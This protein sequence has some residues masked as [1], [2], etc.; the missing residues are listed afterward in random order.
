MLNLLLK[1]FRLMFK[2]NRS[3]V[4]TILSVLF[5][6]VFLGL[7]V[8]LEIYLF[9]TILDK[10]NN[11]PRAPTAFLTLFLFVTTLL[12]I[13]ADLFQAK[14]LFFDAK[15]IEQLST[16]PVTNGQI[17]LSKMVFL[18]ISHSIT[19]LIFQ[20]PLLVAYGIDIGKTALFFFGAFF[21]PIVSFFFV[22]GI[23]LI[24]VY[25]LWLFTSFLKRHFILQFSVSI[26]IIVGLS[27]LYSYALDIF[28]NLVAQN[29]MI[30]LFSDQSIAKFLTF[31]RY[32]V[33]VNFLVD[34]FVYKSMSAI[35]PFSLLSLGLFIIGL[36]ITIYS[37]HMV[38]NISTSDTRIT[39]SHKTRLVGVVPALIKK[40]F[41]LI[42]K[43]SDYIYSFTGLLLVQPLLLQLVVKSINAVLSA[44][45]IMYYTALV[46]G[47][48]TFVDVLVIMFFSVVI[49]Q[50]ANGYITM[51]SNTIKIIKTIP[52]PY[53]IQLAIKVA[54]PYSFSMVS[55]FV[56]LLVLMSTKTMSWGYGF[57]T[58]LLTAIFL[59]VFSLISLNEELH[60]RHNKKKTSFVSSLF[61]YLFPLVFALTAVLISYKGVSGY[62][63][64]LAGLGVCLVLGILP[65][66]LILK[67]SYKHF[68]ELE[69]NN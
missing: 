49:N 68:M 37:F 67:S 38:R 65:V 40:E 62:L 54:I 64:F 55:L 43:N 48:I 61:A 44:G 18:M 29:E 19:S 14:K 5:S 16:H 30:S 56:S 21:Y 12:L 57:L 13:V 33:P 7:F 36:S 2:Q 15:D 63:A 24:L 60:I 45:S 20:F 17:I 22:G 50:G 9:G 6:V 66:V 23:A 53:Q 25:P 31:Q 10:I 51:E 52:V 1:D 58:L 69:A 39:K 47:L 4:S 41:S 27:I 3:V 42:A 35:L 34:M 59:A 46:P 11:I 28:I 8:T 26:V 32:A